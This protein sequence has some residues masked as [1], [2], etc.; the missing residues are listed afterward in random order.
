MDFPGSGASGGQGHE[1][2]G[3][4]DQGIGNISFDA[5]YV[6]EELKFKIGVVKSILSP[7]H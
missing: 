4:L 2:R 7:F 3:C 1:S 5:V 6:M